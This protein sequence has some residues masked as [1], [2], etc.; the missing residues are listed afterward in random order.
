MPAVVRPHRVRFKNLSRSK[1]T[2]CLSSLLLVPWQNQTRRPSLRKLRPSRNYRL[3]PF[4]SFLLLCSCKEVPAV[5]KL[6]LMVS[7]SQGRPPDFELLSVPCLCRLVRHVSLTRKNILE[8]LIFSP[9]A[10]NKD[11]STRQWFTARWLFFSWSTESP[12]LER[13]AASQAGAATLPRPKGSILDIVDAICSRSNRALGFVNQH[14]VHLLLHGLC[15][16]ANPCKP[17]LVVGALRIARNGHSQRFT[18]QTCCSQR[19][20]LHPRHRMIGRVRY[21]RRGRAWATIQTSS[22]LKPSGYGSQKKFS[23]LPT[24]R[25]TTRFTVIEP[26][27]WRLFTDGGCQRN[28]DGTDAAAWGIVVVSW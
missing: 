14:R 3:D 12:Q 15:R 2:P 20:T 25:V 19:Q 10:G 1:F 4:T 7:S 16:A 17:G 23:V 18:F 8:E 27:G 22:D 26:P 9:G 11:T 5:T 13:H 21:G 6:M 24:C 28:L